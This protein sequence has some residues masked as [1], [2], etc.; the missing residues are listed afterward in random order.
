MKKVI[1]ILIVT[2]LY[3]SFSLG[4]VAQGDKQFSKM[5]EKQYKSNYKRLKKEGWVAA[6]KTFT[7]DFALAKFYRALFSDESNNQQWVGH[8]ANC[9]ATCADIALSD[10]QSRY[11][12][13]ASAYVQKRVTSDMFN[14][15]SAAKLDEF[16]KFYAGYE[17]LV[18]KEVSG[19]LKQYLAIERPNKSGGK[20][21]EIW[22]I[23]NEADASNAR[24]RAMQRAFDETKIAQEYANQ[25]AQF[26]REGFTQNAE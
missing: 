7:M 3:G 13:Q 14:N 6:D 22:Y 23:I 25:V 24:L 20:E 16:K 17:I 2:V 12:Q 1:F 18:S 19:L 15:E 26:V 8:V 21:Y 11:A 5:Q 10:A 9:K 4:A